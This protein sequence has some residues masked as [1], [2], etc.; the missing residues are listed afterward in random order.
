MAHTRGWSA[1]TFSKSLARVRE[2]DRWKSLKKCVIAWSHEHNQKMLIVYTLWYYWPLFLF[3]LK[4]C[5]ELFFFFSFLFSLSVHTLFIWYLISWFITDPLAF[6]LNAV[7][8][9]IEAHISIMLQFVLLFLDIGDIFLHFW[10]IF[11]GFETLSAFFLLFFK[12]SHN[13][14]TKFDWSWF[15]ISLLVVLLVDIGPLLVFTWMF[16][17][18]C[19]SFIISQGRTSEERI[20]F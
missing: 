6:K 5:W 9:A 15:I 4:I 11:F 18:R 8:V 10:E 19:V 14:Y 1:I 16:F 20:Y 12:W 2:V 3:L 13:I 7:V 17:F